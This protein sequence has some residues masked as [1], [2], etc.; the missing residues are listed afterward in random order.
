MSIIEYENLGKLNEPFIEEYQQSFSDALKRGR[1]IL[2]QNVSDF[3]SNF[4]AYCDTKYCIGVASGLDALILSIKVFDFPMGTEIVVPA[5]TYIATILAIVLAGYRPVPVEPELDSYNID[6]EKIEMVITDH[7]MAII[8]VHLYGKPCKMDK[9][10]KIARDHN[11]KVIEDCAQA[12]GSTIDGKKVG[13]FGDFGAF[14][15]YPTKNLGALGDGGAITTNNE[16]LADKI[17]YLRNYGSKIR[18]RNEYIGINSRL[19][20][21]QAGFLQIK[22]KSLD[23]INQ[24]K[25][26]LA[27][28]YLDNLKEDFILPIEQENYIDVYHIFAVRHPEREAVRNYL[29]KHQVYTDVHYPVPPHLQ[30]AMQGILPKSDYTITEEIH[31]T[32]FSLPI[33]TIHTVD[34]IIKVVDLMNAF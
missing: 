20:E 19:D 29:L 2:G 16:M 14:S 21:I 13:S 33:S 4:A 24:Y 10:L 34:E 22:L 17:V 32:I 1:F 11:L 9:I 31:K 23:A 30:K 27:R 28:I 25:R 8:V 3:E 26:K 7:T 18:N 12:H 15:F 5:N 6:P